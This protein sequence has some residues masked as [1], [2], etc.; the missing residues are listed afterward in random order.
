[1]RIRA[2]SLSGVMLLALG[3]A[4]PAL[5]QEPAQAASDDETAFH[6]AAPDAPLSPLDE[7]SA[8]LEPLTAAEE[9]WLQDT[10]TFD[11]A[12]IDPDRLERPPPKLQLRGVNDRGL[13]AVTGNGADGAGTVVVAPVAPLAV[14][15][16]IGADL[17]PAV[18]TSHL[19]RTLYDLPPTQKGSGSAW[20]SVGLHE[21]ATL[22]AR[23]DPANDHGRLATTFSKSVPVGGTMAVTLVNTYAVTGNVA[24]P[25]PQD[26]SSQVWHAEQSVRFSVGS[27]GTTLGAGVHANSADAVWHNT[28]SAEQKL[29]G[30]LHVTTAVSDLGQATVN[31]RVTAGFRLN[32]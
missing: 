27:T 19:D 16:K 4:L 9:F 17:G 2:F 10:L 7:G 29:A 3:A 30:P 32:W 8:P 20:A 28:L 24:S 11:A 15:A 26:G 18:H 21:L 13:L 6:E 14:D 31:K 12:V 5:A 1:M 22:D 25:A 23:V